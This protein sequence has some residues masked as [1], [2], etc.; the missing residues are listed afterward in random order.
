MRMTLAGN[1]GA[2][3]LCI[4]GLVACGGVAER[5]V[6]ERKRSNSECGRTE[7][8]WRTQQPA[9]TSSSAYSDSGGAGEHGGATALTTIPDAAGASGTSTLCPNCPSSCEGKTVML[10]V[11]GIETV[12]PNEEQSGL[13]PCRRQ[14]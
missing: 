2:A 11:N 12:A 9:A 10:C 13:P 3:S 14:R 1:K 4:L 6:T 7:S 8:R 5:T